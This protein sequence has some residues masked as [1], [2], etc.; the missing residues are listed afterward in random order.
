MRSNA[1]A[2]QTILGM[3]GEWAKG[4]RVHGPSP[5]S[6]AGVESEDRK[7][8][9]AW[10]MISWACQLLVTVVLLISLVGCGSRSYTGGGNPIHCAE[11]R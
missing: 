1:L 4:C 3:P 7:E 2:G 10:L 11:V 8:Y 5:S 9:R 6:Y